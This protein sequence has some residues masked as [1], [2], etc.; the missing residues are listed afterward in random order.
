M[1]IASAE[2][3]ICAAVGEGAAGV[4]VEPPAEQSIDQIDRETPG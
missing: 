3:Q 1:A 4:Y 2:G